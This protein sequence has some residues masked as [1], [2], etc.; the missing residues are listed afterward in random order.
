MKVPVAK[1]E[2]EKGLNS[3]RAVTTATILLVPDAYLELG[4]S[5]QRIPVDELARPDEASGLIPDG[6][7]GDIVSFLDRFEP[8]PMGRAS[9]RSVGPVQVHQLAIVDPFEEFVRVLFYQRPERN[10]TFTRHRG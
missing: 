9:N 6:K 8:L 5:M 3:R 2:L 4:A 10:F 1:P 7:D